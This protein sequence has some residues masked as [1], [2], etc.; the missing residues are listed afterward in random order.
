MAQELPTSRCFVSHYGSVD[1]TAVINPTLIPA[2]DGSWLAIAGPHAPLRV[3][4]IGADPESA[5][6]AF[7]AAVERLQRALSDRPGVAGT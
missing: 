6:A 1:I 4:A 5:S 2:S 3:G 7:A